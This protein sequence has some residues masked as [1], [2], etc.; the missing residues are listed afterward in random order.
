MS[1]PPDLPVTV[2]VSARARR[3][4]L[5]LDPASRAV[6]L[7]VP[8]RMSLARAM[9]FARRHE[10]WIYKSLAALPE[11]VPFAEGANLSILGRSRRI[12]IRRERGQGPVGVFLE[13]DSLTV[14]GARGEPHSRIRRFLVALARE[15][16]ENLA[17]EK[18]ARIGRKVSRLSVRDTSSRWGS[19]SPDGAIAFSWRLVLAPPEA[20]D[21][22]VAHEVAHLAHMNHGPEFWKLCE[23]LSADFAAGRKWM[24]RHGHELMRYGL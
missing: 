3:V 20:M 5:R 21:Y 12:E 10:A 24:R 7:V 22:V 4:A 19:C 14:R 15:T 1:A 17:H 11:T 23:S 6:R 13:G 16:L 2:T 8:K 9:A 18:A